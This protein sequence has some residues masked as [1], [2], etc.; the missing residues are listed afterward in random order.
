MGGVILS[1]PTTF[2]ILYGNKGGPQHTIITFTGQSY[3][4]ER[5][6]KNLLI[7]KKQVLQHMSKPMN[8]LFWHILSS[9]FGEALTINENYR[10]NK[11]LVLT[12]KAP[13][14]E[15]RTSGYSSPRYS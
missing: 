12:F 2:T 14:I 4:D 3:S 6:K 11:N 13:R 1:I 7:A 5:P 15:P 10:I 8:G 9:G